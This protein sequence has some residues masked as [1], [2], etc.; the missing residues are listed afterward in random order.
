MSNVWPFPDPQERSVYT[1]RFVLDD[2]LPIL[3]VSHD[4]DGEWEFLCGTTDNPKDSRQVMLSEMVELDPRVLEVA[5]LPVGWRAFRDR[6]DGPWL[7]Q[8][9]TTEE[10]A[11][12]ATE[13]EDADDD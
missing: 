8:P 1:T 6:L 11:A 2:D 5:D 3:L 13:P 7:Q 10:L 9:F 12:F 4:P